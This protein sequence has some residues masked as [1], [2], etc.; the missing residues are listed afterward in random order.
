MA[1]DLVPSQKIHNTK[2]VQ[3]ILEILGIGALQ[4]LG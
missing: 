2:I 4:T 1:W 3:S